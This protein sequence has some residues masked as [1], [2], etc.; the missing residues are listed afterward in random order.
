MQ[1]KPLFIKNQ[2][3]ETVAKLLPDF[4]EFREPFLGFVYGKDLKSQ[5]F[6]TAGE[7]SVACGDKSNNSHCLKGRTTT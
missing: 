4:D 2:A 5:T 1:T 3:V 7:R 6:I